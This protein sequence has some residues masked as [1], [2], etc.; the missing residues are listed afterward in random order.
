M[1][2]RTSPHYYLSQM[3]QPLK[4]QDKLFGY[5]EELFFFTENVN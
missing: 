5:F 3:S 1:T 2:R 4:E